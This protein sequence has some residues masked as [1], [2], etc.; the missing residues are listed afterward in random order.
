M[1]TGRRILVAE[2]IE[3]NREI[4]AALLADT[5]I[6]IDMAENGALAVRAFAE[7]PARYD[8]IFMDIHMP[9]MDGFQAARAIR[10]LDAPQAADI[11]IV[12]MTA[13][14]F[15]EDIER[16]LEAGMNAHIGKPFDRSDMMDKLGA[17]LAQ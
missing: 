1:F 6:E 17:Y 5:G 14:V 2:D 16:C 3:I 7:D 8:L 10:A 11:P 15:R 4:V 13:N 9:E 12:A